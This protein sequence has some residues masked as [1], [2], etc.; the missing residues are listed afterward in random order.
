MAGGWQHC[1][2]TLQND[3]SS[4][5][6]R[7][8]L[9]ACRLPSLSCYST[10]AGWLPCLALRPAFRWW[11]RWALTHTVVHYL[12]CAG[13]M[14]VS[15]LVRMM[16]FTVPKAL[17]AFSERRA[18][19]IYKHYYIRCRRCLGFRWKT[20]LLPASPVRPT[21]GGCSHLFG[22]SSKPDHQCKRRMHPVAAQKGRLLPQ[23]AS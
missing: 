4:S 22:G 7:L 23:I 9:W 16:A 21:L 17:L 19:G 5:R 1:L 2:A 18:P 13:Y 11:R 15:Y 3:G 20:M 12:C 6:A 10:P 8:P 14:I